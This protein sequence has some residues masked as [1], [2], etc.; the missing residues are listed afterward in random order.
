MKTSI[1]TVSLSGTLGEKLEAI[2]AAEVRRA[3]RS[4][5][6]TSS[7]STAR[8][9]TCATRCAR[10]RARHHHP[11]AVPR[12]RGHAGRP[13]RARLRAR[14]AQVRRHAGA[15]QR[16]ADDLQQRLARVAGRHRPRG[17]RPARARRARGQARPAHRLRGAGLGPAHQRLP[18]RLGG[19]A[20]RRPSGGRAGARQLPHPGA[21]APTSATIRSIPRDRIFLVQLADAPLLHMDYLS[22][23]RHFRNF[24]GQGELPVLD[25]MEALLATGYDG[26]ALARDLQRPVPRRLGAQRR[27]STAIARCVFLLD[28]LHEHQAASESAAACRRARSARGREFIEFALDDE[29]APSLESAAGGARLPPRRPASLEGGD[30]LAPGRHQHRRQHARRKASPI[31]STSRTA[32]R[33]ARSGLRVDDAAATLRARDRCCSTQPF[34]QAVGPGELD[35]PAVRGVG[36]SLV[37]FLDPKSELGRVW[38]IEFDAD[39]GDAGGNG[40]RPHRASTTSRSRCTTRRC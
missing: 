31:P 21:R 37:Y 23:S 2:A 40:G 19:G 27:R 33:S 14:R 36:G 39:G 12:L 16:P 4:S 32:R 24:P 13:A 11:A 3:W 7:P 34:R 10:A 29:D 1:A 5:R 35:I 30:A 9:P 20:P 26:A 22:W 8:R 38:D 15:R 18:R 17:R 6:T 28:Q 25:F